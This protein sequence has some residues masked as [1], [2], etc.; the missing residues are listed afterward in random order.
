MIP[1][2]P[3][4]MKYVD[5]CI[6]IDSVTY[7][8]DEN[9]NPIS[10]REMSKEEVETVYCYMYNFLM[11][12]AVKKR[13]FRKKEDYHEFCIE[14]TGIVFRRLRDPNQDYTP[15]A[16]RQKPIKSIKNY[17]DSCLQFLAVNYRN[18]HFPQLYDA[19]N[20]DSQK[21]DAMKS[22]VHETARAQERSLQMMYTEEVLQSL[23]QI[24]DEV[25]D[26]SVIKNNTKERF[27]LK[28]NV[29]L[30]LNN[31]IALPAR[32]NELNLTRRASKI[33]S[34][35]EEKHKYCITYHNAEVVGITNQIVFYLNKLL[36]KLQSEVATAEN[37]GTIS[38][39]ILDAIVS[40]S[41]STYGTDQT[42][43]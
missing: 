7:N 30:T 18:K 33:A 25:F 21:L 16:K 20:C 27:R 38:E 10:L 42:R 35:L 4:N 5:L 22:Y 2:K 41:L 23:P 19:D 29:L 34:Q 9:N 28:V 32:D 17:I 40:S 8:R 6:Y 3:A 12:L 24:L 15:G 13:M 1:R 11:A 26:D 43:G 39:N 36:Q 37:E 14:A 31:I